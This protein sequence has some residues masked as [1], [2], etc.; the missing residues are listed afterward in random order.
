[1]V[2][3]HYFRDQ[4]IKSYDFSFGFCIP[5][6]T[7]TWE[8]VYCLPPM[9]EALIDDMIAHPY[10]TESDSFYFVNGE[11]IMHNKAL[12]KYVPEDAAAPCKS[13]EAKYN[14]GAKTSGAKA[15]AK[16]TSGAKAEAKPSAEAKAGAK[17]EAKAAAKASGPDAVVWSKETDYY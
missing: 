11:L 14:A 1:M 8:A 13:Y 7:N 12:Y 10:Q 16:T 3:R 5:G 9:D 6:S 17:P 2:E 4:L 15:E